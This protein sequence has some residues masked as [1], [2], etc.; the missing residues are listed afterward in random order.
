MAL[1]DKV[2]PLKSFQ[3]VIRQSEGKSTLGRALSFKPALIPYTV[4]LLSIST[5]WNETCVEIFLV[6]GTVSSLATNK[7]LLETKG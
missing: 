2:F 6:L 4:S 3:K 7:L 1:F 5:T